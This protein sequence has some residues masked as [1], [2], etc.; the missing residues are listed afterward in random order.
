M[1]S[2]WTVLEANGIYSIANKFPNIIYTC[3]GFF[4]TAWKESAA[5]ILFG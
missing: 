4:S 5:K 1:Q 2:E 3:Y